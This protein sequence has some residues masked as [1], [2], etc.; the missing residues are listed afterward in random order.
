MQHTV[1]ELLEECGCNPQP[2]CKYTTHGGEEA[3][4]AGGVEM[5]DPGT[6]EERRPTDRP[7]LTLTLHYVTVCIAVMPQNDDSS[8][9][10]A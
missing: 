2:Y 3:E 7:E 1:S 10:H 5:D 4:G 6:M 8:A 9:L